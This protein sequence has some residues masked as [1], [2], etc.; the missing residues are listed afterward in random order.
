MLSPVRPQDP[1]RIAILGAGAVGT[2]LAA[3][4]AELGE[5]LLLVESSPARLAQLRDGGLRFAGGAAHYPEALLERVEELAPHRPAAVFVCTKTWALRGL[6]PALAASV[7]PEAL[8]ISFQNGIGPE[9]E[10]RRLLPEAQVARGII[11]FAGNLDPAT[12]EATLHWFSPPNYLGALAE[13]S[14]PLAV[15]L[16]ALLGRAG[17]ETQAIPPAEVRSRAFF[18]TVLSSALNALCATTGITM[19]EAMSLP[20]T[21][22]LAAALI[23]E[24]LAVA[25]SAGYHYG[26]DAQA[27]CMSYLDKG[28][29]HHPSMWSDLQRGA[30]TEIEH[31]NG[32]LVEVGLR[33]EGVGVGANLFFTSMVVSREILSGARRAEDVPEYLASPRRAA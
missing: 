13:A 33:Y 11:N 21:R 14:L 28:G 1:R 20:H 19:A 4:L 12:G 32:K 2:I 3:R 9:D 16:A 18:K 8:V 7:P 6:L 5:P 24:G 30:L 26:E 22:A 15:E 25:A 17:L 29:D 31:I 10:L 23:R 27:F